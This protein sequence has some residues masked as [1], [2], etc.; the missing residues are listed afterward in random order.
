MCT[1]VSVGSGFVL[2]ITYLLLD[3]VILGTLSNTYAR[4]SLSRRCQRLVEIWNYATSDDLFFLVL[5]LACRYMCW[6]NISSM[7]STT[8]RDQTTDQTHVPLCSVCLVTLP[9]SYIIAIAIIKRLPS[10]TGD[11]ISDIRTQTGLAYAPHHMQQSPQERA[12]AQWH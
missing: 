8:S 1:Y 3:G 6:Y 7:S 2:L 12:F 4:V 10:S 5:Y 9:Y 11:S